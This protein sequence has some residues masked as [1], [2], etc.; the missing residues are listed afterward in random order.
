M[1]HFFLQI[2]RLEDRFATLFQLWIVCD[3]SNEGGW[4]REQ[5]VQIQLVGTAGKAY[6]IH[7]LWSRESL[8]YRDSER[9][10]KES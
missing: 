2:K 8:K 3:I 5:G 9:S 10:L 4:G 7:V 1:L 6:Y